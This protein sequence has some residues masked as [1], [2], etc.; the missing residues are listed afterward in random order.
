MAY[1]MVTAKKPEI[2]TDLLKHV[3]KLSMKIKISM[4][5]LR[6]KRIGYYVQQ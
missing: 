2:Q 5:A 3:L 4:I 1:S 6:A